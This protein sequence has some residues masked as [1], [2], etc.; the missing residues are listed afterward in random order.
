MR[1][2]LEVREQAL[3]HL[4]GMLLRPSMY[5]MGGFYEAAVTSQLHDLAFI[6]S[7]E[8]ELTRALDQL[9]E[10]GMSGALGVTGA[11][12]AALHDDS[13]HTDELASIYARIAATL[14]YFVPA[15]RL[16][17]AEWSR[18]RRVRA[19]ATKQPRVMADVEERFG[20][21]SYKRCGQGARIVAYAG[22]TD[23]AWLYFDFGG[24]PAHR[25]LECVRLPVSP[26][27]R[28]LLELRPRA[29]DAG[30]PEEAYRAFL[31]ASLSG[32][33][34][35]ILPLLATREDPAILCSG[36]YPED[37]ALLLGATYEAMDVIRVSAATDRVVLLS[38]GCPVPL[39]VVRE[40]S[41]WRVDAD[42]LIRIRR[43]NPR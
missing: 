37:V 35:R 6:D 40:G 2:I 5:G 14:G 11:L 20:P 34:G 4:Q 22:P 1:T 16:T 41:S 26:F 29:A 39:A 38:D 32:D 9:R 23:E 13:D 12:A 42:P 15:R 19:W 21:P 33:A 30:S 31:I 8:E 3:T 7:R 17:A 28:S 36:S 18:A 27:E 10:Q 43:Q 25:L 24:D